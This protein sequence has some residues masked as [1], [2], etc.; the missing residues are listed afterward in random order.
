VRDV[1]WRAFGVSVMLGLVTAGASYAY[2]AALTG[3]PV[4][5]MLNGVFRSPWFAPENFVDPT[6]QTGF[7]PGAFW[8]LVF[9]TSR[10]YEGGAG[11]AGLALIALAG[12][13]PLALLR[14]AMRP[15]LLAALVSLLLVFHQVQYLRYLHPCLAVLLP[16]LAAAL[17]PEN[18]RWSWREAVLGLLVALQLFLLPTTSWKFGD[19]VL[20][21]LF[22]GTPREITDRFVPE[23]ELHED[24]RDSLLPTDR[25]LYAD[26]ARS[27]VAE[28]PGQAVGVAWFAPLV[29]R[30]L[31]SPG[32]PAEVWARVEHRTG[33]NHVMVHNLP[34][35]RAVAAFLDARGAVRVASN[36]P[37][38]VYW[39]PPRLLPP[40]SM[41]RLSDHEVSLDVPL[42]RAYP[43]LGQVAVALGCSQ[44]GKPVAIGW[45]IVGTPTGAWEWVSCGP[46]GVAITAVQFT[47]GP[48]TGVLNLV[49]KPAQP[50]DRMTLRG[51]VA[52]AD[53]RRDFAGETALYRWVVRPFCRSESCGDAA[54]DSL[55]SVAEG[56]IVEY[57]QR[58][59]EGKAAVAPASPPPAGPGGQA[60]GEV[61]SIAPAVP[62]R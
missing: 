22:T 17:L 28:L 7:G 50:D 29:S 23:R 56:N 58:L 21:Q 16:A 34:E 11:A 49:A 19:G 40:E 9:D 4:L 41:V 61:A 14:P 20:R 18:G 25:I 26:P 53:V 51:L 54:G 32:S 1:P 3:N 48:R 33:V 24:L 35:Q 47:A 10:Y 30:I 59:A 27:H 36:G 43:A 60:P 44:P 15:P 12:G 62:A 13:I 55:T 46:D 31:A 8:G 6:W 52:A 45:S 39:L 2:A 57:V 38:A 42:D 5:P 37:A